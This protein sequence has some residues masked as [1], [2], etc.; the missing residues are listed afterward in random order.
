M[1]QVKI[2]HVFVSGKPPSADATKID[3]PNWDAD[4]LFS[5]AGANGAIPYSDSGV[6]NGASWLESVVTGRVLVSGGAGSA[7]AWSA[8]PSLTSATFGNYVVG[9]GPFVLASGHRWIHSEGGGGGSGVFENTGFGY[10][11]LATIAGNGYANTAVGKNALRLLNGTAPNASSN[12]AGGYG[13]LEFA[14]TA[15]F[16]TCWGT[17]SGGAITSS[18]GSTHVGYHAGNRATGGNNTSLGN[19]ALRGASGS[20]GEAN[21]AIGESSLFALSSGNLNVGVGNGTLGAL[22]TGSNHACLGY[23]S[24]AAAT[25]STGCIGVGYSAGRYETASDKFFVNNRN[26]TNESGD[27]TLSLLYGIMGDTVAEQSLTVNGTLAIAN[28]VNSVSPTSPNRTITMVVGGVTLY[29]HAKTTN[30]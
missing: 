18:T 23:V 10:D 26:R 17:A 13:A 28:T 25:T 22:T 15:S 1:A 30:D 8:T 14:T 3:G 6:T 24:L 5:G 9:S 4:E 27:R 29:I 21:V 7:P 11:A 2:N 19:Q 20:S 12:T 16:T